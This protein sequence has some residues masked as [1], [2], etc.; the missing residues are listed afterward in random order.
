MARPVSASQAKGTAWASALVTYLQSAGWPHA[1]RRALLGANDRGDI[2][3][4]VGLVIEAKNAKAVTLAAWLDEARREA[5][6]A[7]DKGVVW[8][9]RR[10]RSSPG[11]GFVLMDGETFVNL[12]IEAG[13]Q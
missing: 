6:H 8:F 3:G 10:G 13:Y 9:H 4:I 2:A 5:T 11:D 7:G 12:L 1:E